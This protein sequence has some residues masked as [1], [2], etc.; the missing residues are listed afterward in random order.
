M[1]PAPPGSSEPEKTS[2]PPYFSVQTPRKIRVSDPVRIGV[3]TSRP[4]WVSFRPSSPL[5]ATPMMEKIVQTAKQAVKAIVLR[6]KA[7]V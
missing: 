3:A 1:W 6:L 4:N 2:R 5:M 7:R